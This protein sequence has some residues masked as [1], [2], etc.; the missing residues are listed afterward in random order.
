MT[1]ISAAP[2]PALYLY[3]SGG[4]DPG[5]QLSGSLLWAGVGLQSLSTSIGYNVS[6]AGGY[7]LVATGRT[8]VFAEG[9]C[10]PF[11]V[12]TVLPLRRF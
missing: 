3:G 6:T 1:M 10:T 9:A 7:V 12:K 4:F 11:D 8:D 5:N 2:S